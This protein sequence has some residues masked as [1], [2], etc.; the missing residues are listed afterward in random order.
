MAERYSKTVLLGFIHIF[1]IVVTGNAQGDKNEKHMLVA[2]RMI[3]H[4][5][6]LNAGD[7]SS[8][9]LPIEDKKGRYKIKFDAAFQFNPD[10]LVNTIDS[11]IKKTNIANRYIVEVNSCSTGEV[12]YSYEMGGPANVDIVPCGTRV[13]PKACYSI[14]ISIFDEADPGLAKGASPGGQQ[15]SFLSIALSVIAGVMLIG[16]FVYFRKKKQQPVIGDSEPVDPNMITIG[17]YRF[18]TVNS[19]LLFE[20]EKVELSAKESDLLLLLYNAVNTTVEREVMLKNIWRDD[21][22]YIGRTLD[23]FISKLRKKLE[24]DAN[25]RII[26]SRGIGYKLVLNGKH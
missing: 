24:A 11:V 5:I 3:G 15:N 7:S 18:D 25:I 6:L 21:G 19:E 1:L 16:L 4:Q 17:N 10:E 14:F 26:N 23:V 13:P 8:R 9:V 2:M 20:N 12:V 22:D